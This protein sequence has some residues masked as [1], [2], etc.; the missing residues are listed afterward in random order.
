MKMPVVIALCLGFAIAGFFGGRLSGKDGGTATAGET[1]TTG[2]G[3]TKSSRPDPDDRPEKTGAGKSDRRSI[4]SNSNSTLAGSLGEF[5]K[6]W[7]D[8]NIVLAD[9]EEREVLAAD[10]GQLSRL[11]ASIGR[12]DA[13]DVAELRELLNPTDET[14]EETDMLKHLMLLPVLGREV[15]LRGSAA[16]DE[17]LDK[18]KETEDDIFSEAMPLMLYTLAKQNPAEAEKWLKTFK[19]RSDADDFTLDA[20]EL[21]AIIE[22]SKK[23]P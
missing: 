14:S 3:S 9:G 15:E 1:T 22:K 21:K 19:A 12:A 5:I 17:M 6:S 7:S 10:L 23:A 18:N 20:D 2:A 11:M 4:S 13:A 16:L 8:Q